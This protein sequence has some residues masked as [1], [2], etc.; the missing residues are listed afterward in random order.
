M[1]VL[2]F[3]LITIVLLFLY[4]CTARQAEITSLSEAAEQINDSLAYEAALDHYLNATIYE[5]TGDLLQATVEYNFALLNDKYSSAVRVALARI[6]DQLG[7][8]REAMLVLEEGWKI[9]VK[10]EELLKKLADHYLRFDRR[11]DAADCY[12]DIQQIRPL[13][14]MELLKQAALFSSSKRFDEALKTYDEYLERFE[15]DAD[16][17]QKISIIHLSLRDIESA[18]INLKRIVELDT[19][20]HDIFFVLGGFGVSR[21]DWVT[22]EEYFRIAIK[23]DSTNIKY[24]FNLLLALGQQENAEMILTTTSAAIKRFGDLPQLFDM[25]AGAFEQDGRHQEALDDVNRSIEIDSSRLAPYITKGYLHHEL[26][27]WYKGA[28]AYEQALLI[29]PDN[30][31]V[32]NNYAYLLSEQNHRLEDALVM[33]NRAIELEPKSASYIDTRAWLFYRLGRNEEALTELKRAMKLNPKTA[34]LY[35]HLGYIYKALGKDKK[36]KK[37]WQKASK[38]EPD[39]EEYTRLAR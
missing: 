36:A 37:A 25:R 30:P 26:G 35:E 29:E 16:V 24:W 3:L 20:R 8:H 5:E 18:E 10:D 23:G 6:Y 28:E 7:G 31:V 19:T 22:A 2:R 15:P 11:S 39:N 17:Y 34:E 38:L 33:V 13:E 4:G 21:E 12:L 1:Q 14:R 32:L 9:D 27:E